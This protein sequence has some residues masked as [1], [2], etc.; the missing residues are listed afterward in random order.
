[1][2]GFAGAF[3]EVD[4]FFFAASAS[5]TV[6]APPPETTSASASPK[7]HARAMVSRPNLN[8]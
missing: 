7:A 2:T 8:P 6:I 3:F 4:F 5:G 1:M